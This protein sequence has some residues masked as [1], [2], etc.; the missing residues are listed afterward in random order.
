MRR[1]AV[2]NLGPDDDIGDTGL[3][4]ERHEDDALGRAGP[5]PHQDQARNGDDLAL[6][7]VFTAMIAIAH[8]AAPRRDRR[9]RRSRDAL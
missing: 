3:V 5:L 8:D 6:A 7:Q 9:G 2:E 4:F 1:L